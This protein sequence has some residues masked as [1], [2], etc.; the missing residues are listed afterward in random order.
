[1]GRREAPTS[2][3]HG[4]KEGQGEVGA[5]HKK[6]KLYCMIGRQEAPG[7]KDIRY[8]M[9]VSE[10]EVESK[11]LRSWEEDGERREG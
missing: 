9:D 7:K 1:M 5:D 4:R 8:H 2:W 6:E 3:F 10:Q 11:S